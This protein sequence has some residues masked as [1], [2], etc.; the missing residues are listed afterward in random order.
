[1]L[2][3]FFPRLIAHFFSILSFFFCYQIPHLN[4]KGWLLFLSK[5]KWN[6]FIPNSVVF[7]KQ[8][9]ESLCSQRTVLMESPNSCQFKIKPAFST[10]KSYFF[11]EIFYKRNKHMHTEA[12]KSQNP[13]LIIFR[14]KFIPLIPTGDLYDWNIFS[15]AYESVSPR[16]LWKRD[17]F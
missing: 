8:K 1:M 16:T 5:T 9:K 2:F 13:K 11:T 14:L 6:A 3:F 17:T 7:P 15:Q 10:D 4:L 12:V